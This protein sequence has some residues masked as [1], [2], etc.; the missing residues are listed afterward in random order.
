MCSEETKD[1]IKKAAHF[2]T[3]FFRF[4]KQLK[5]IQKDAGSVRLVRRRKDAGS[6]DSD[7]FGDKMPIDILFAEF[8]NS[9]VAFLIGVNAVVGK[10]G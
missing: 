7:P 4:D 9:E 10:V 3:V 2:C 5:T 6:A 1:T 8:G